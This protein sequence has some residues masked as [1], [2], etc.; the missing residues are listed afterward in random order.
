MFFLKIKEVYLCNV[1]SV[2]FLKWSGKCANCGSWNSLEMVMHNN[3]KKDSFTNISNMSSCDIVKMED[4]NIQDEKRYDTGIGE[5]NRVLGGGLVKGSLLLFSGAP[6]IGK[7]TLLLQLCKYLDQSLKI[8]YVSGEESINQIKLRSDRLKVENQNL[9]VISENNME[10]IESIISKNSPDVVI[11]DSIQTVSLASVQASCGSVSQVREST[12]LLMSIGKSKNIPIIL[13]GHINKDGGIAGPKVLEH[14]VDAVL[15]FEGD[16]NLSNRILRCIKNRY[17]S[18]N[19]IGVFEMSNNGLSE[20]SNP[21]EMLIEGRPNNVSGSCI[22]CILEGSRPILVEVQALVTKTAFGNPR[23]TAA[24]F[25]YN[26]MALIIAIIEKRMGLLL[27][28]L[29]VYLNIVGGFKVDDPSCDLAIACCIISSLLDKAVPSDY[30]L[31]GEIGL[32]GEIRSISGIEARIKEAFYLGFSKCIVPSSLKKTISNNK[33][34]IFFI[35]NINKLT[36]LF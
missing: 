12:N 17:G 2:E 34:N 9:Y 32:A 6:G 20:I 36:K 22:T 14:I 31:F 4:I 21:S 13:V 24:G 28:D 8:L 30:V 26:R 1:C 33:E 27:G 29:D 15:Y 3:F 10:S 18:T 19:E 25:D 23:R 35:D 11:I 16:R 7:S 5:V